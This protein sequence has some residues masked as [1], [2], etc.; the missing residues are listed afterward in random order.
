MPKI[1][2]PWERKTRT[3]HSPKNSVSSGVTNGQIDDV[4][5]EKKP[6]E[7][8]LPKDYVTLTKADKENFEKMLKD[9]ETPITGRKCEMIPVWTMEDSDGQPRGKF[10]ESPET[11]GRFRKYA[12]QGMNILLIRSNDS[13][14]AI[15]ALRLVD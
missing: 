4:Q 13:T 9:I 3:Q 14:L 6:V 11:Q 7:I 2:T 8:D 5:I 10:S 15:V 12:E 1:R